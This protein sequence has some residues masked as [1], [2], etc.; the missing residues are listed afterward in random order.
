MSHGGSK[1]DGP[2]E[3]EVWTPVRRA[4][5]G[6]VAEHL[7]PLEGAGTADALITK[8]AH[9]S[10]V[11]REPFVLAVLDEL[12]ERTGEVGFAELSREQKERLLRDLEGDSN[13][14]LVHGLASLLQLSLEVRLAAPSWGGNPGGKS[15]TLLGL[16]AEGLERCL[17]PRKEPGG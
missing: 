11:P 13:P 7:W 16:P 5:L 12:E 3:D 17:E 4:V 2:M 10:W 1:T 9:P 8:L 15:W 6:A 14:Y